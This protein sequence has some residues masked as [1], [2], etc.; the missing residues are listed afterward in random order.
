MTMNWFTIY[1]TRE[2][3]AGRWGCCEKTASNTVK[4]YGARIQS[5]M[6]TKIKFEFPTSGMQYLASYDGVNF[7]TEEFRLDPSAKWFD[8]KSHSSGLVSVIVCNI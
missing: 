2:V 3:L 5:L 6:A 1:D 7:I 4:K 8:H